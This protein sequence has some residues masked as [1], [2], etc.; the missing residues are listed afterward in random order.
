MRTGWRSGGGESD[1]DDCFN[2][3]AVVHSRSECFVHIPV[4]FVRL[5]CALALRVVLVVMM[6]IVMMIIIILLQLSSSSAL[7]L[8]VRALL[9]L[10]ML[11]LR[12]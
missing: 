1:G 3:P 7:A 8:R 10:A 6:I 12:S 5:I 4:C 2:Y 11:V 9:N